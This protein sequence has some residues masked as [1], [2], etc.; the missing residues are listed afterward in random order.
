MIAIIDYGA[1]NLHSV[2]NALDFLGAES[3]I[4]DEPEKILAADKVILPGVG[5]FGDAMKELERKNLVKIIRE[6]VAIDKPMLGICLGLQLL[7]EESEETPG[8]KGIG[9]LKGKIVK[10]P[11]KDGIKIPH[12]GWNSL[13][14]CKKSRIL[15]DLDDEPYVYFVHSYYAKAENPD[16]VSAYTEYSEKLAIAVEKDNIFATQFHPEKSGDLG[17][18]ILQNFIEL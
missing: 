6:I 10:I 2:K 18:K 8:V 17:L 4:T 3:I 12:M 16:D 9:I 13:E 1:G 11:P 15:K 5:A 14:I 7:F